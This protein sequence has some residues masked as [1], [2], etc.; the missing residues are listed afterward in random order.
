M[1]NFLPLCKEKISRA[2]ASSKAGYSLP[3]GD[4]LHSPQVQTLARHSS[5]HFPS[6]AQDA[7]SLLQGVLSC[8]LG[9]LM[10]ELILNGTFALLH[11]KDS[12][13]APL[14]WLNALPR[15]CNETGLSEPTSLEGRL[16]SSCIRADYKKYAY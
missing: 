4:H 8:R 12:I 5:E 1:E 3:A 10:A 7:S 11:C 16:L 6:W 9:I 2:L 15:F 14:K 13:P